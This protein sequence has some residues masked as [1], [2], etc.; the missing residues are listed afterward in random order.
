MVGL[1]K[2][3][4]VDYHTRIKCIRAVVDGGHLHSENAMVSALPLAMR[5]AGPR[6]ALWH[7][8]VRKNY[9]ATHFI[10]GRDHAGPGANSS[11]VDFY[12][13]YDARDFGVQHA[14]EVGI[15]TCDFE[16]MVY[17]SQADK[18]VPETTVDKGDPNIKKISGTEVRN[19]LATGETSSPP[20]RLR[21][22]N[23]GRRN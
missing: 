19:R 3:G 20:S 15:E 16:M 8:L 13:P 2:P 10:L 21:R 23:W 1:T 22:L 18:Y 11:G 7:M 5:M 4:D 14:A 9:G 12:G 17:D 6:E